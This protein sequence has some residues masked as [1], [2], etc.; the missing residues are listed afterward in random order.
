MGTPEPRKGFFQKR[1]GVPVPFNW[2]Y[3]FMFAAIGTTITIM[4]SLIL[5][6]SGC[7][8]FSTT[9][10][11]GCGLI[12]V[13]MTTAALMLPAVFIPGKTG[14][15]IAGKYT[16]TGTLIMSFLSGA[17]VFLIRASFRNIF[18][19]LWLRL[20]NSVVFPALFSYTAENTK[21]S[22]ALQVFTDT[23]IPALGISVFFY[24]LLWSGIRNIDKDLSI[25]VIPLLL[26]LYSLNFPDLPGIL[27]TGIWLCRVR[28]D[29]D[30][31]WGPFLCLS[32]SRFFSIIMNGVISEVDLTTLRT[33][34]DM[35][36]TFFFSSIPALVVAGILFAFFR[37]MLGDFN[38]SYTADVYGAEGS[39]Y[40]PPDDSAKVDRFRA[41]FNTAFFIGVIIFIAFWI[42]MFKGIRL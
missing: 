14:L 6:E 18:T 1:F 38:Y 32:G 2:G 40:T 34:S 30:N 33:Y 42:L 5:F 9:S 37:K 13:M 10:L 20:G 39:K 16:G 26:A 11:V 28:K 22:L 12:T 8:P 23:L 24:G 35:P 25:W 19:Y 41:G 27:I 36:V 31:I 15:D 29:A 3:S 21:T 4:L 17:P 7:L